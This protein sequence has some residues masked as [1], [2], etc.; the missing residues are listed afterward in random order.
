MFELVLIWNAIYTV[1]IK[2][3]KEMYYDLQLLLNTY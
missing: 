3:C 1:F 2:E